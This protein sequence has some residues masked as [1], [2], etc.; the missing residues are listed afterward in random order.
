VG[1]H[2]GLP[3]W[4]GMKKDKRLKCGNQALCVGEDRDLK[5]MRFRN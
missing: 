5:A 4:T 2:P 3:D 1:N